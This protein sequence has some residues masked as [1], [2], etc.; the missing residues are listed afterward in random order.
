MHSRVLWII[1]LV[2]WIAAAQNIGVL[3]IGHGSNDPG[4][5]ADFEKYV[6][7]CLRDIP[8]LYKIAFLHGEPE[9]ADAAEELDKKVDVI[10]AVYFFYTGGSH[11]LETQYILGL[12]RHHPPV[13]GEDH[14]HKRAALAARVLLTPP[15]FPSPEAAKTLADIAA[16]MPKR[17]VYILALWAINPDI[18]RQTEE[19]LPLLRQELRARGL[20]DIVDFGAVIARGAMGV[21]SLHNVTRKYEGRSV[22]YIP[23][24]VVGG[25]PQR[26]VAEI[27]RM[28]NATLPPR[29]KVAAVNYTYACDWIKR[30][31][32][33]KVEEVKRLGPRPERPRILVTFPHYHIVLREAFPHAEV[34]LLVP[35]GIDPHHYQLTP[36]DLQLLMGLGPWDLIVNSMHVRFELQIA[37]MATEG[38][39]KARNLDVTTFNKYLT[40]D[41]KITTLEPH[42]E[43]DHHDHDHGGVNMHEHGAYPPNVAKLVELVARYLKTSP[44]PKFI[45]EF[46]KINATYGGKFRGKAVALTPL[47]QYIL[48]WLGFDDIVVFVKEPGVPPTPED[49]RKAIQY[50][51]EGAPVL[52]FGG[53][54]DRARRLA[55]DFAKKAAEAG[56]EVRPIVVGLDQGGYLAALKTVGEEIAKAV[57]TAAVQPAAGTTPTQP[58]TGAAA[59]AGQT[60]D[61]SN[62]WVAV[63]VAALAA[64]VV[65]VLFITRRKKK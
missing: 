17:D 1:V 20:S 28:Y 7:T 52:A 18:K 40:W 27:A 19:L 61:S 10:I 13:S 30:Q 47:S 31:I 42:E 26:R 62:Q 21:Y 33:E 55:E 3:V 44:D 22:G 45:E 25:E 5:N 56:V 36:A 51:R 46:Q 8:Y 14:H 12:T 65:G 23:V 59:G 29:G 48:H 41:G 32:A 4:W 35:P 16:Q 58:P 49:L 57:K 39:I 63:A 60:A 53:A 54:A 38:R 6:K 37:D 24:V 9:V 11:Y 34:R 2:A 50:A 43:D 15:M 64:L